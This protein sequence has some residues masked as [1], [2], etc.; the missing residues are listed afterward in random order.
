MISWGKLKMRKW[1]ISAIDLKWIL[2]NVSE[3]RINDMSEEEI[4]EL[5]EILLEEESENFEEDLYC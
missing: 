5:L 3:E 4:E 2:D 1:L